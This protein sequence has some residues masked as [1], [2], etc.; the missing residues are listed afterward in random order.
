MNL[1]P[2]TEGTMEHLCEQ[3][4]DHL[5]GVQ[6]RWNKRKG[7][8]LEAC[9][10][11][12]HDTFQFIIVLEEFLGIPTLLLQQLLYGFVGGLTDTSLHPRQTLIER[13]HDPE[14]QL[15]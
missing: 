15:Q 6:E 8:L 1:H 2:V 4:E 12:F 11:G 7:F 9:E 13:L 14:P 3:L 5:Q 10:Y